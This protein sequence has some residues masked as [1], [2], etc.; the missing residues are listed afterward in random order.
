MLAQSDCNL[1]RTVLYLAS[2]SGRDVDKHP[3]KPWCLTA[4]YDTPTF[5]GAMPESNIQIKT[6]AL[7]V[8][9]PYFL[10]SMFLS[11][12]GLGTKSPIYDIRRWR[13]NNLNVSHPIIQLINIKVRPHKTGFG[14]E[15]INQT[16]NG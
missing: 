5:S 14:S 10:K 13:K 2:T 1:L 4:K 15:A 12:R 8:Y 9:I 6:T 3:I 7:A 16:N 11:K